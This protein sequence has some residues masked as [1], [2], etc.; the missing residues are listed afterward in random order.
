MVYHV[1]ICNMGKNVNPSVAVTRSNLPI[2]K[3]YLL[4]SKDIRS[5]VG[6]QYY[7]ELK[8]AEKKAMQILKNSGVEEVIVKEVES[9]DFES[10]IDAILDIASLERRLRDDVTFHINFTSGTHIMSGAAC[11]AAFYIGA[12]LYYVMNKGDHGNLT[13]EEELKM[14]T[15]PSLP[16]VSKIKGFTKETLLV[17][18]RNRR[19]SNKELREITDLSPSKQGYHTGLLNSMGLIT[20]ERIGIEVVWSITYSGNIASRILM[21]SATQ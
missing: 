10:T 8:E 7:I 15:I 9:W 4:G 18:E 5:R 13:A 21:R 6:E 17:I 20:S 3:V 2:D 11:C 1:H 19:L 12:D 16:D 14:F